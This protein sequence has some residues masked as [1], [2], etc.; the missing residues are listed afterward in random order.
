D[1]LLIASTQRIF[2]CLD[3]SM[4]LARLGG[5]E[6]I[7]LVPDSNQQDISAL[8]TRIADVIGEPFTLFEHTIRVSLSAGSSIYPEHGSTLHELKVTAD[9]A[10]YHVKQ[11]GR[12][13]WAIYH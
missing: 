8:L 11:A 3:D 1:Q 9:M 5:D 2:T 13:G 7:L 4:T 10:M 12:N 6:F